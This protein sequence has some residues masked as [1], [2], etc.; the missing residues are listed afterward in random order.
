MSSKK[1]TVDHQIKRGVSLYS[2]QDEA[3]RGTHTLKDLVAAATSFGAKGIEIIPEQSFDN[4][5]HVTDQQVAEWHEILEQ[6]GA[7]PTAYDMFLDT[8]RYPGRQL[9]LEE[10]A[11]SLRRDI[12]LAQRLGTPVIRVIVSTEPSVV[13]AVSSYAMDHNVKLALEV[14]APVRYNSEWTLRHLDV[15]HKVDNG[16]LGLLPD[17]GT[18]T[19]RLPRILVERALR[20]GA[21]PEL[22]EYVVEQY[23]KLR[24]DRQAIPVEVAW[25]GGNAA[26]LRFANAATFYDYIDPREMLPHM[27]YIFHIQAKFYDMVDDHHEYSIPYDEIIPVLIEG[28]YSGYLSSEYEGNRHIEDAFPVNSIEQVRRQHAMFAELL[29]ES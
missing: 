13:E 5:P 3:F 10:S 12:D 20:E 29:G 1:T 11:D 15:I 16:Y 25:K 24:W 17:M 26:D 27:D 9:T 14:H 4:F 18:F 19:R 21:T 28:G 23:N 22:V 7:R 2:F 6:Y 8:K